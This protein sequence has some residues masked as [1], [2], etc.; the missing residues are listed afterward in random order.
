MAPVLFYERLRTHLQTALRNP[1]PS[2]ETPHT[3]AQALAAL[4]LARAAKPLGDAAATSAGT[5]GPCLHPTRLRQ[6]GAGTEAA[7]LSGGI[8]PT[9]IF[10]C[11]ICPRSRTYQPCAILPSSWLF[12]AKQRSHPLSQRRQRCRNAAPS[13]PNAFCLRLGLKALREAKTKGENAASPGAGKWFYTRARA[14]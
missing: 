10:S 9:F 4:P 6:H 3:P 11:F 1:G 7:P 8:S 5:A 12:L 2:A 14:G 13:S